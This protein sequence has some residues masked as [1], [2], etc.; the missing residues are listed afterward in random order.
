[1]TERTKHLLLG[2]AVVCVIAMGGSAWILFGLKEKV[3]EQEFIHS[4]QEEKPL[5]G[6]AELKV[7]PHGDFKTIQDALDHA[8]R[9]YDKENPWEQL[10][11]SVEGGHTYEEEIVLG[12]TGDAVSANIRLSTQGDQRAL[13]IPKG[14]K[15]VI[16]LIDVHG[17]VLEGFEID[18]NK[19]NCALHLEGVISQTR[20]SNLKL[21]GY[22]QSGIICDTIG[23]GFGG[24]FPAGRDEAPNLLIDRVLFESGSGS[25]TG[26]LMEIT[27]GR[28]GTRLENIHLL[29][30]RFHVQ[31]GTG[32]GVQSNRRLPHEKLTNLVKLTISRNVFYSTTDQ[33]SGV[34]IQ[35]GPKLNMEDVNIMNNKFQHLVKGIQLDGTSQKG[36]ETMTNQFQGVKKEFVVSPK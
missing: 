23:S 10:T 22:Q 31:S 36:L 25:A 21:K 11:I 27:E 32:I 4:E 8:R 5:T 34:G 3:N 7:G 33:Q 19:N 24:G 26:V 13:L 6:R 30:C 17:F 35:I 15:P 18:A 1:M 28:I 2:S 14:D 12:E 16:S 29:G 9:N 20:L